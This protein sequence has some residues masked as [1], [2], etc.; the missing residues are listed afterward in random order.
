MWPG[1]WFDQKLSSDYTSSRLTRLLSHRLEFSKL[2]LLH[3]FLVTRRQLVKVPQFRLLLERRRVLSETGEEEE[4][5][6]EEDVVGQR[7]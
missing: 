6:E 3:H 4:E 1:P 5:E 2:A 7:V